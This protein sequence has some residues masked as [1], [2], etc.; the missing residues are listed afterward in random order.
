MI[1]GFVFSQH[2]SEDIYIGD[3]LQD[4]FVNPEIRA[5]FNE[6]SKKI[7][8]VGKQVEENN[9]N[10]NYPSRCGKDAVPYNYMLP[11][12]EIGITGR[13]VTNSIGM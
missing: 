8:N 13:G 10:S 7:D 3:E 5:M 6:F 9:K 11:K 2:L 1:V 12:S 4:W